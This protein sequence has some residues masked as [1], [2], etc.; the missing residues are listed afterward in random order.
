[1]KPGPKKGQRIDFRGVPGEMVSTPTDLEFSAVKRKESPY[2]P[3]LI[4]LSKAGPGHVLKFGDLK[5]RTSVTVRAKKKGFRVSFAERDGVLFVRFDGSAEG[6]QQNTRKVKILE[7][8]KTGPMSY[9]K[10]CNR[11]RDAGDTLI[12]GPLAELLL[13]QML[14]AGQVVKQEGGAYG[15]SPV[16]K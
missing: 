11:L 15:L 13:M 1:L 12:D 14:K 16:K 10:V 2:D 3:L 7:V 8:L 6:D 4:Q 9:L 5:A